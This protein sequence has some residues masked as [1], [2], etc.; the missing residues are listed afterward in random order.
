MRGGTAALLLLVI[1]T[2]VAGNYALSY[3]MK[4]ATGSLFEAL[5]NP[6]V[7]AGIL[8]L[9]AWML[10]RMALLGRADLSYVLPVT[11][12]GYA[13]NALAARFLLGEPVSS[14]RWMGTLLIV[15]GAMLAGSTPPEAR[16]R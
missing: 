2:N 4:R 14:Q 11:A 5:L 8:T 6:I 3:G 16:K 7:I 15:A 9:I 10:S 13:L 1:L 12:V